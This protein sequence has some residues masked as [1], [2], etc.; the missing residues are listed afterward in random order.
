MQ[1]AEK[2]YEASIWEQ[3]NDLAQIEREIAE[4]Q[5][6][7]GTGQPIPHEL[8]VK[9]AAEKLENEYQRSKE[10]QVVEEKKRKEKENKK[11]AKKQ[12]KKVL[13]VCSE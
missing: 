2:F 13:D 7:R 1:K 12:K 8:E 3:F 11:E 6:G 10:Y 9:V 5:K 4:Q